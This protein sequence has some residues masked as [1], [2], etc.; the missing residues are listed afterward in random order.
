MGYVNAY[1]TCDICGCKLTNDIE[2]HN[3][4]IE[5]Q[6]KL[7]VWVYKYICGN[8]YS[9]FTSASI[10]ICHDCWDEMAKQVREKIFEKKEKEIEK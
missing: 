4:R 1:R 7:K 2:E 6:S 8:P 9:E 10:D 5:P 3:F